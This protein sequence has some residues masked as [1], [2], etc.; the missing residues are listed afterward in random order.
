M[1]L[2]VLSD[3]HGNQIAFDAVLRD[4][5]KEKISHIIILGDHITDFPQETKNVIKTIRSIT[6]FALKGNREI[7]IN[8]VEDGQK[9]QQFLATYLTYKELS[10]EELN[11]INTL[12]EQISLYF[13]ENVT[14]RCVHGSPFSAFEHIYENEDKKNIE[15]LDKIQERILL[16]GHTHEQ[17]YKNI[18]N[19]LILNP[20]SVGIN[21]SGSKTAQYGIV[22]IENNKIRI[23]LKNIEYDFNL[24]KK[25]CD[26]SIP[27][28]KL[29]ISG[30]EDGQVY[31]M[32]FLE[33]AKG[34][35]N[36]WP[37]PNDIWNELFTDWCKR[38]IIEE[39]TSN[40]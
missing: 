22:H 3:I 39:R 4:I 20:G 27:W 19:K 38:K 1:K 31:T 13:N 32:K 15:I 40:I 25:S 28:I 17:W 21:F 29:C 8:G 11:Y 24:F 23:E 35:S 34:K 14:I 30:I 10:V 33:E 7:V 37:I 18:N 9:Y 16:C 12:P 6:N 5:E 2:A 26:L 36:V